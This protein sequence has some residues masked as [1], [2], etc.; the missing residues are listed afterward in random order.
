MNRP[1][2]LIL[3]KSTE[4]VALRN[5]EGMLRD[6]VRVIEL[7]GLPGTGKSTLVGRLSGVH[8]R[9]EVPRHA[10]LRLFGYHPLRVLFMAWFGFAP[11]AR[12]HRRGR[13]ALRIASFVALVIGAGRDWCTRRAFV[14]DE[15]PVQW[16]L[17]SEWRNDRSYRRVLDAV[18]AAYRHAGARV[19]PM[20]C[21]ES[22]RIRRLVQRRRA[23][24]YGRKSAR[25]R[26]RDR[27]RAPEKVLR[28]RIADLSRL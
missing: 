16:V 21:P 18:L 14:L 6:D 26:T 12:L 11:V 4:Q 7:V 1:P 23:K 20:E 3:Q 27:I 22:V 5:V 25:R 15:G 13:R 10:L 17:A 28:S 8:K 24:D 2:E 19:Q 9:F